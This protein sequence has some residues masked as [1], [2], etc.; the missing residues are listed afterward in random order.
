M[1]G[2]PELPAFALP[3]MFHVKHRVT[4][5]KPPILPAVESP[6][7]ELFAYTECFT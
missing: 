1:T 2:L 4:G 5:E 7:E 3:P 6:T